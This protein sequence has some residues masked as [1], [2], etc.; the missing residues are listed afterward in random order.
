VP[1]LLPLAVTNAPA[2]EKQQK[3][4]CLAVPCSHMSADRT[5]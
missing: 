3:Y 2:E 4:R 5:T 1:L